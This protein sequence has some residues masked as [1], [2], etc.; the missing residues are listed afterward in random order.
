[1]DPRVP[2]K[3]VCTGTVVSQ[4]EQA[5]LLGFLN[6]N[7]DVFAWSTSDLAGGTRDVIEQWLQV[8]P[9]ARPKK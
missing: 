3:T 2:D 6:K 8:S 5:K 7:S 4:E 9:S 1:L